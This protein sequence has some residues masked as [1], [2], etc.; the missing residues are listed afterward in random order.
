MVGT[1][2]SLLEAILHLYDCALEQLDLRTHHGEHPRIGAVDVVPFI[3]LRG[4]TLA[5]CVALAQQ[6]AQAVSEQFQVPVYLYG[7]A[8]SHPQRKVLAQIRKGGFEGLAAKMQDPQWFP[9]YGPPTPHPG[10]G[11]S[12]IGARFFLIA[13][14][15][16]LDTPNLKIAQAIAKAVR[17]SSGGLMNLQA[18]GVFLSQRNQAQ[19]SMNL[20]NYEKTPLHR[21]QE[22]VKIEAQRY[23]ARVLSAEVVGLIPQ[24]ALLDAAAY[25]LQIENWQPGIVLE[26]ALLEHPEL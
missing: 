26:Q 17:A 24:A 12:V 5:D 7:E 25:Y 8:A 22:L 2:D 6:T 9:D 15:L 3:P 20:L 21:V 4:C 13:Y 18:I 19:V 23:G 14:N 1:P 10:A 11:A 16:Q